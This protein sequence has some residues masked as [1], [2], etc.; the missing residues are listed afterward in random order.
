MVTEA[1]HSRGQNRIFADDAVRAFYVSVIA[2]ALLEHLV[3][4]EA[5]YSGD[6]A[7]WRTEVMSAWQRPMEPELLTVL[8]LLHEPMRLAPR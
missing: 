3:T 2:I 1:G 8:A 7:K 4:H 5:L 6:G